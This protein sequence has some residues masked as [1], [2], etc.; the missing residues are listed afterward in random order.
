LFGRKNLTQE[1]TAE[2]AVPLLVDLEACTFC[3]VAPG[4]PVEQ[5]RHLGPSSNKRP[6]A[7]AQTLV[8]SDHGFLLFLDGANRLE[9]FD[10]NILAEEGMAAYTGT[11][12]FQGRLVTIESSSTP[13]QIQMLLGKP[14]KKDK[15]DSVAFLYKRSAGEIWFEWGENSYLE[16]VTLDI[17]FLHKHR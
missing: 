16:N 10:I 7:D 4:M 14:D 13:A 5:L 6:L 9:T 3:G 17:P 2:P 11:W 1:W 8:Y 15:G 12:S